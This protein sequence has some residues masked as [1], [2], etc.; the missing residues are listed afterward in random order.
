MRV[1]ERSL[2][3]LLKERTVGFPRQ[4]GTHTPADMNEKQKL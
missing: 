4:A 1:P 2:L 3:R